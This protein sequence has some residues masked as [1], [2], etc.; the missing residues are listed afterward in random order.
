MQS[1]ILNAVARIKRSVAQCLSG[2]AITAACREANHVWRERELGPVPTLLAFLTQIVHGNTACENAVQLSQLSCSASAYCR[3][4]GRLPLSVFERLLENTTAVARSSLREP[5]WLGHRTFWLDGSSCSMPDTE[6]LQKEFGQ[7]GGQEPGC[8]FPVA[9]L[10]CMFD[11]R[12]GLLI[13]LLISPFRTNEGSQVSKLHS[14][15][16][17]GDVV[18]GDR[19]LASYAHLARLSLHQL[20][21]VF[22]AH[23]RQLVSFRQDRQLTGKQPKG[24][25]AKFATG[26]L[27]RKLGKF[28]QI[29][30]YDK[31]ATKPDWMT[32]EEFGALPATLHVR[33]LRY[34]TKVKGCRTQTI[35]LVTT[36]LDPVKYSAADLAALNGTRWGIETNFG[37]LKTT[38]HMDVLRCQTVNGV[39]KELHMYALVYNLVRLVMLAAA[40][41]QAVPLARISFVAALRWIASP[42]AAHAPLDLPVNPLRPHR[43]EPRVRKRRPKQFPLM[44]VPRCQLRQQLAT[45]ELTT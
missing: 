9:K 27:V 17:P 11:A 10:C 41:D 25:K 23:Q 13:K 45:K 26:R 12:S 42:H 33:E 21:G 32:A 7:P 31:P 30:E 8:G 29:V 36:L 5:R 20:H 44:K 18:V 6:A 19:G 37:Y 28:D 22:R 35:T 3:A 24:T 16:R 14:A 39:K 2:A 1:S 40:R 15:L 34:W 4:R 43:N 38:M